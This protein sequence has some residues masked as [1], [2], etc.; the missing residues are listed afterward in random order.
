MLSSAAQMAC[1]ENPKRMY[2]ARQ[3]MPST[4]MGNIFLMRQAFFE[5]A[6]LK[7][8]RDLWECLAQK[9][10]FK[11]ASL[12]Q[13]N[14]I[15]LLSGNAQAHIHCYETQDFE[16]IIRLTEE[17]GFEVACFHHALEAYKIAPL[18]AEK[19]I[20]VCTFADHGMFK[21]EAYVRSSRLESWC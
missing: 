4:R 1:G 11:P 9:A 8:E 10:D 3:Q 18:L 16:G 6:Q 17:F 7:N 21:V 15:Q 14:L 5:A 20:S 13:D 12:F 2:G 19:G